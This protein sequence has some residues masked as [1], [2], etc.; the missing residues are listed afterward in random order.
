[1]YPRD[2]QPRLLARFEAAAT[3][4]A[5]RPGFDEATREPRWVAFE[6]EAMHKAVCDERA[7]LGKGPIPLSQVARVERLAMGHVDYASKYALYC[8]ELVLA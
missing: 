7:K 5:D 8:A 4:R 6:L 2:L 1:M 3:Q